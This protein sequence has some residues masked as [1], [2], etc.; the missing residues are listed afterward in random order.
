MDKEELRTPQEG[1]K[2]KNSDFMEINQGTWPLLRKDKY[3][4]GA[5]CSTKAELRAASPEPLHIQC[6]L[7]LGTGRVLS[8]QRRAH[9]A[10]LSETHFLFYKRSDSTCFKNKLDNG[11]RCLGKLLTGH[12]CGGGLREQRAATQAGHGDSFCFVCLFFND[13]GGPTFP[14]PTDG[15]GF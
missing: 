15:L 3:G 8:M 14:V 6:F 7:D 10:E 9:R 12:P 1:G 2:Q 4:D 11:K 13:R 5:E